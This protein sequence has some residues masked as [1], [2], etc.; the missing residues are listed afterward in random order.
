MNVTTRKNGS[1]A[2][3]APLSALDD[4]AVKLSS[5]FFVGSVVWVPSLF[6]HLYKKWK[7]TRKDD[8][9]KKNYYRNIFLAL[10][11]CTILGPHRHPKVGR[12]LNARKWKLWNAWL[13]YLSFEVITDGINEDTNFNPKKDPAILAFAPHGIFPFSLAF[14]V[15]PDYAAE[16]FGIFRPVVASATRLF[17]LVRTLLEWI[18]QVDASRSEVDRALSLGHRIGLAPG[19]ISEM[20]EGYPKKGRH[21]D[22]ECII[23][24]SRKGFIKM[25]LKHKLPLIPIYTF[26]GSKIMRRIDSGFLEKISNFL[27]ISLCLFYGKF[28]LPIPFRTKLLY[29]IGAPIHPPTNIPDAGTPEFSQLVDRIHHE[30]CDAMT[31]LFDKYKTSYGWG[32]KRLRIV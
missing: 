4:I 28:G 26:G 14:A 13:R 27:R 6:I 22:E 16:Y 7:N 21:P 1:L 17:P 31:K 15:L 23:L 12:W 20:F 2:K 25:A 30:F 24:D 3:H 32:H 10:A 19:G 5:L 8:I 11:L 18:G 9:K 29:I